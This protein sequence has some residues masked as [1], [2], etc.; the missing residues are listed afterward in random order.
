MPRYSGYD[1][2][3]DPLAQDPFANWQ[4]R[5]GKAPGTTPGVTPPLGAAPVPGVTGPAAPGMAL[6]NGFEQ[7]LANMQSRFGPDFTWTP[8]MG[9][10][11]QAVSAAARGVTGPAGS[12]RPPR[13]APR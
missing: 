5:R 13:Q 12:T 9:P 6:S 7:R 2:T 8:E 4:K 10:F 1:W 11:G 3:A